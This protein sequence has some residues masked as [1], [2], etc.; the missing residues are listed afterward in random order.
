MVMYSVYKLI[1]FIFS[2]AW[3]LEK[4][5]EDHQLTCREGVNFR[6]NGLL[7]LGQVKIFLPL[8]DDQRSIVLR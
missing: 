2:F 4:G 8:R 6:K 3:L 7:G 5:K 1:L